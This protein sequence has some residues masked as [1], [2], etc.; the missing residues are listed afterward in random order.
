M[1]HTGSDLIAWRANSFSAIKHKDLSRVVTVYS[2]ILAGYNAN[3]VF[4]NVKKAIETG[5][6]GFK[7]NVSY[8]F[9]GEIA[10]LEKNMSFLVSALFTALG[11]ILFHQLLGSFDK[12]EQK[13]K[14]KL[15]KIYRKN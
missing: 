10:E 9:T 7:N 13:I 12:L 6:E 8:T 14:G 4:L 5:F 11:L 15:K 2:P 3:E 1:S